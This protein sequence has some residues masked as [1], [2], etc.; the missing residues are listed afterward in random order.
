MNIFFLDRDIQKC[1]QYHNNK[2]TIKMSVELGQLL[3]TAIN[4]NGGNAPY[5]TT[6]KNHP[7]AVWVR[8]NKK[9]WEYTKELAL[10]LCKE[11]THRYGK[12]H[13]TQA[14]LE[15][16]DC[17]SIPDQEWSDPPQCMPDEH[18]Q[19][20]VVSAYRTYYATSK[21]AIAQWKNREIPGWFK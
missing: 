3:C 19:D 11:Y 18:K 14:V 21:A 4:L 6:H 5:K 2:H 9:H 12:T 10:A 16:I 7:S 13:K 17:P 8:S 15:S 20:D 1:A